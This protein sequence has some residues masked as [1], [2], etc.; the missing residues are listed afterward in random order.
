MIGS[1]T[2]VAAIVRRAPA[3]AAAVLAGLVLS[4][5]AASCGGAGEG[6]GETT[7]ERIRRTGVVRVGYAT[8]A[9]YAYLDSSSDELTGEAPEVARQVLA[10]LGV[11]RIEGVLT[12]F[13]ALIPGLKAGRF[14][15]I[16]A[17]M[18]VTP[19]RCEEIDFSD[20]TYCI[21][22]GLLVEA[23]NPLGLH[24]YRDVRESPEATIG[25]VA[26]AVELGYARAVGVPEER[27]VIFPDAPSAVAGVQSGRVDGYAGTILTVRDMHRKADDPGLAV[28]DPFEN[29]VI[30][31]EEA[32]G[33]GAFGFRPG[34]DAFRRTVDAELDRFLGTEEHLETV[35]PFGF[36][37]DDLP[38]DVTADGLCRGGA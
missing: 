24:S 26:G 28:A 10:E 17:G 38:G 34:D 16:A 27:I 12:E 30:G 5:A 6:P 20:P 2:E 11:P 23:G 14:D 8:E 13:G 25:V 9:P 32:M 15:V 18:Y 31:G 3:I 33:C 37:R 21:G 22:E 36:T 4:A 1:A 35:E 7:L 19:K 29:P